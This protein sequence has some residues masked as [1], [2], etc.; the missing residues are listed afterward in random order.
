MPASVV[1]RMGRREGVYVLLEAALP[2]HAITPLGV[3]LVDPETDRGW[4]RMRRDFAEGDEVLEATEDHLRQLLAEDGASTVL[5]WM[6][7]TL[8]NAIRVTD[9]QAVAVDAFS[10]VVE[11]L[12][13]EHVAPVEV[14]R[15]RTHVPLYS[16]KAAAGGLGEE[17]ESVAEDW[18]P[19][20]EGMRGSEDLF[21]AHVVGDSMLPRIPNGS[22]NLFRFHPQGSRQGKNLLIQRFGVLDETARFT[23]KRYTSRKVASEEGEW[24]HEQIRLEPLN[25]DYEAWDLEP[26]AFAVVGEWLRVIE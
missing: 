1:T 5:A 16:L 11:R 22:L 4:L 23:V 18:V 21:V 15:F 6:E 26:D 20:P 3:L 17:M 12:Y 19:L 7:D 2:G 10:R 14:Q 25:P 8:S 13:A 9:R 24:R